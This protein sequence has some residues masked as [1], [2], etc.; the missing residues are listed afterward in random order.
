MCSEMMDSHV[1]PEFQMMAASNAVWSRLQ[2]GRS[3][4]ADLHAILRSITAAIHA[5]EI[6]DAA[7]LMQRLLCISAW[8][9][10]GCSCSSPQE[11]LERCRGV[12]GRLGALLP[13]EVRRPSREATDEPADEMRVRSELA[14]WGLDVEE[15]PINADPLVQFFRCGSPSVLWFAVMQAQTQPH[16][17][18]VNIASLAW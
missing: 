13:P 8:T 1:L 10:G 15:L 3:H 12:K 4:T 2:A 7:P 18:C 6:P 14:S 9:L 17:F 5:L 11:L 16:E